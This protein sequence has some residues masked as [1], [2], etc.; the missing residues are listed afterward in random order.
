ML[1]FRTPLDTIESMSKQKKKQRTPA[2]AIVNRRASFDYQ[3]E[4]ELTAGLVLSGPEVRA[5]R[6]GRVQLKGS[7]VTLR[8]N[9]LWLNNASF[10]L[11]L[12]HKGEQAATVDTS[13]R[14]L[15]A[16]RKQIDALNR[17]RQTGLSIVPLRLL[18]RGRHVKLV[19]ALGKGKKNYDKRQAIKKRDQER[20]QSHR[21]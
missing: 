1:P 21:I 9:E 14:K 12:N 10:S 17:E 19:I 13:P 2:A 20:D 16:H 4:D 3:L 11:T 18:T 6:D 8:N 5:A 15:L 7:F